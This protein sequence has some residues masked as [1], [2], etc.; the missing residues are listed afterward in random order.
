MVSTLA[1][2]AGLNVVYSGLPARQVTL[3][4]GHAVPVS[5]VRGLLDGVARANG[6]E[7]V[8][9]KGGLIR[10]VSH[11]LPEA[12]AQQRPMMPGVGR[13]RQQQRRLFVLHLRNAR[14]RE[15]AQTL[16]GIFGLNVGGGEENDMGLGGMS[17]LSQ[18]LNAARQLPYMAPPASAAPPPRAAADTT[19]GLSAVLQEAVN[20]VPD[21]LTNALL[22]LATPADYETIRSAV[23]QLDV[24]PLQ[25]LIEVLIVEVRRNKNLNLGVN[26][27]IPF[28][29][30]DSASNL[31]VSP[32]SAGDV[33]VQ[34]LHLG[35]VNAS[36]LLRALA[37]SGDVRIISR[38]V[39]LAQNNQRARI[40]VGDQ[41]PFIQL[42]R[43]LPTDAAV[44]DQVVQ[45]RN[46]GTQ[47]T[48]RPTINVGGYVTL[49]VL[50]EVS[51]ATSE[52]QFG[53]PV[54]NT[55]EAETQ[56][57]VRN[58]HTAVLGGLIDRQRDRTVSGIPLL[59]DIP[60][61]GALFRS[62]QTSTTSTELFLLLTPHVL[63]TDAAMDSSAGRVR[64]H[65]SE[66][67]GLHP[68]STFFDGV[69]IDDADSSATPDSV[70]RPGS[71]RDTSGAALDRAV[72]FIRQKSPV[73]MR[74]TPSGRAVPVDTTPPR[75]P[76][77]SV[78]P[79]ST[80]P[81]PDSG[82]AHPSRRPMPD[83]ARARPDS[84]AA[85][86][87][88]AADTAR[89]APPDGSAAARPDPTPDSGRSPPLGRPD[90][91]LDRARHTRWR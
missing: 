72:P 15:T 6:L 16:G 83:T 29:D 22:I 60:I 74:M 14:A 58:G 40:L 2:V 66:V 17:S 47:L 1:E 3:R 53:A 4:T 10:V 32:P 62:S 24:R 43:A 57:M 54:I 9:D 81:P 38:P 70:P 21:E 87:D 39:L 85:R 7:L 59:K 20:I 8:Q 90:T 37:A 19:G 75:A 89:R 13:Q 31:T 82:A 25:V 65:L 26:A 71:V 67:P 73:R 44:R 28:S 76:R 56:L 41:R 11:D 78:V 35:D 61:L 88:T 50:Q 55:R 64:D 52:T 33:V 5:Q 46:V 91:A 49:S 79:D 63:R 30:G 18:G 36:V 23:E 42:F 48:I 34:L 68:D 77:R 84:G 27:T 80:T 45:Y 86:K 69:G 12:G 51:N